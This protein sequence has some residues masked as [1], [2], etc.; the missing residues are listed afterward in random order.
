MIWMKEED[1]DDRIEMAASQLDYVQ[2]VLP[3]PDAHK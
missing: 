1:Y 2:T 3:L